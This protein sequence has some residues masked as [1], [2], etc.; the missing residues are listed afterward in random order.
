MSCATPPTPARAD[1]AKA[2]AGLPV[3]Q[4]RGQACH[5]HDGNGVAGFARLAGQQPHYL[6]QTLKAYRDRK[7]GR[8]SAEMDLV[9]RGLTDEEIAALAAD[10]ANLR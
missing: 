1:I 4:R 5:G 3:Y 2:Q 9:T 8:P 6:I 10:L 7:G